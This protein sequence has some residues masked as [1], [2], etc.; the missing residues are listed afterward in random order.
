MPQQ[1]LTFTA[2]DKAVLQQLPEWVQQQAPF[3]VMAKGGIDVQL[4][5]FLQQQHAAGVS[6]TGT[7]ERIKE[8]LFIQHYKRELVYYG[9][10]AALKAYDDDRLPAGQT[11]LV[12]KSA[13]PPPFGE[14]V[15]YNPSPSW[16][17]DVFMANTEPQREWM[18]MWMAA[19]T[20][21]VVKL[22]HSFKVTKRIRDGSRQK[23]FAC[24]LTIMNEFCQVDGLPASRQQDARQ[25]RIPAAAARGQPRGP[26]CAGASVRRCGQRARV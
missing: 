20:S 1:H 15:L 26:R 9:F 3:V 16:L 19:L 22:D 8:Q 11:R 25:P 17:I 2:C 21:E 14:P 13:E 23:Q 24:L 4:A 12:P 10:A 7:A 18:A 6:F 5:T